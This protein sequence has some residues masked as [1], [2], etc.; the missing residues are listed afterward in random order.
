MQAVQPMLLLIVGE[1]DVAVGTRAGYYVGKVWVKKEK[2]TS[3]G[4]D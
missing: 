2:Q 3:K 1:V 4:E